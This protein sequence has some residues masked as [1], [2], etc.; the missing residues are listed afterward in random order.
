MRALSDPMNEHGAKPHRVANEVIDGAG[1]FADFDFY[2][3][4]KRG[5]EANRKA[6]ESLEKA[7]ARFMKS[8]QAGRQLSQATVRSDQCPISSTMQPDPRSP[9]PAS[10]QIA[11]LASTPVLREA[12][13][14]PATSRLSSVWRVMQPPAPLSGRC[15][16]VGRG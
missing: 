1:C 7:R 3:A 15:T 6:D 16:P 11:D 8:T 4:I 13:W 12:A 5:G 9:G 10:Q 14:R 2:S